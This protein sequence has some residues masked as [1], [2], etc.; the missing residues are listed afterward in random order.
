MGKSRID[1]LTVVIQAGGESKRMGT[2]K[3]L[4]TFLGAPLIMRGINRLYPICDEMLITTNEPEKMGFLDSYVE[5]GRLR[6]CTD[7]T[8]QRG[9]LIGMRTALSNSKN[10][11]VAMVACDMVF[12]SASLITY[13]HDVLVETGADIA[14]PRTKFGYEPFHAVYRK[15]TCLPVVEEMLEKGEIKATSWF[16]RVKTIEVGHDKIAEI[17]PR[18]AAFI[19][20]NTPDK[21]HEVEQRILTE[22]MTSAA[23]D[24]LVD[25]EKEE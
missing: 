1:D 11:Y 10:P 9:A 18:G 22:G 3:A 24:I 23:D 12:P 13:L 2:S 25:S 4:V 5:A 20:V 21:L 15:D 17:H 7:G 14:V 19:N 6:L 8:G 16:N